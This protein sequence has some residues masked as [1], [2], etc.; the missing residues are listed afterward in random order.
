MLV[1]V[2]SIGMSVQPSRAMLPEIIVGATVI[3]QAAQV[4]GAL[5]PQLTALGTSIVGLGN[6]AQQAG[7]TFQKLL[8]TLFPQKPK[9]APAKKDIGPISVPTINGPSDLAASPAAVPG[10]RAERDPANSADPAASDLDA[11]VAQL[12]DAYRDRLQPSSVAFGGS[13]PRASI[14]R[15]D[16]SYE[17]LSD[18]TTEML[19]ETVRGGDK[20][21][22]DRF[23]QA[24]KRL[25]PADRPAVTPVIEQAVTK[26][27]R[28]S[29][30][31]GDHADVR[32][33]FKRLK[34]LAES[35]R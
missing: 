23:A 7:G 19:I 12:V 4:L 2:L 25:A 33:G 14:T 9:A 31:Y 15:A 8:Q 28:F 20:A 18:Q 10:P 5:V 29:K 30:I 27:A 3:F 11:R 21:S 1:L 13:A 24:V 6:A 34:G 16:T 22:L 35:V 32:D 26:G 17:T